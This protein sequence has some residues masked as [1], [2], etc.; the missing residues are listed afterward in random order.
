M[1]KE[2][3]FEVVP[4]KLVARRELVRVAVGHYAAPGPLDRARADA[5]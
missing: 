5:R 3:E 2:K 1:S 4:S